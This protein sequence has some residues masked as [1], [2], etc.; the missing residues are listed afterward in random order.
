M[1]LP[2]QNEVY[3]ANPLVGLAML[4]L[5]RDACVTWKHLLTVIRN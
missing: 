1:V 2:R 5:F 3:E 4:Y